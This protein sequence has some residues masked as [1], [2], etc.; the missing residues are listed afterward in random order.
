MPSSRPSCG[1]F[2]AILALT[3]LSAPASSKALPIVEWTACE[4]DLEAAFPALR[5]RLQCARMEVPIDHHTPGTGTLT[6]DVLRIRAASPGARRGNLFINPGGPGVPAFF[7]TASLVGTWERDALASPAKA[8]ISQR[9]DVIAIQ[10][11]GLGGEPLLRCRS[12]AVLHP[13]ADITEDRSDAN[14]L[15]INVHAAAIAQACQA[16]PLARYVNTG[17]TA[18]DMEA[19]RQ[20]LGGEPLNYWGVSWGTELGA[21][22]GALFPHHVDRM[23]LD[24][25]VDWTR[26]LY[27]AWI[28]QGPARQEVFDRF[29]VDRVIKA[30]QTWGLGTSAAEVHARFAG[31]LPASR[32]VM[33]RVFHAPEM[34]LALDFLDR[35]LR[36]EPMLTEEMLGAR[37][38]AHRYSPEDRIDAE[39]RY[40]AGTAVADY[41][42]PPERPSRLEL[43]PGRSVLHSV[44]CQS[45]Q[46]MP[47]P[48]FWDDLGDH[49]AKAYPVGGSD[50]SYEP[51]A[52]WSGPVSPRPDM[53]RLADIPNLVL[54]QAEYDWRTPRH[55]ALNA[56]AQ[57]AGASMVFAQGLEAHGFA[58]N[59]VSACVDEI[60]GRFMADGIKPA[61]MHTCIDDAS[62]VLRRAPAYLQTLQG[63]L[64][65]HTQAER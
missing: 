37:A 13:Y 5:S 49:A 60:S 62:D 23:I 33:R 4:Q 8:R 65:R 21:W 44:S 9:H 38:M 1:L 52:Y 63:H 35:T 48:A 17:Q 20:R 51:C 11:R 32:A 42:T 22:Y 45:S 64:R 18:R 54:L 7:Y 59:G 36:A 29:V 25:N 40:W 27:H 53:R 28:A 24:S 19:V 34:M 47:P 31:F 57:V 12:A 15:A 26:D 61:R 14:L 46:A 3:F 50:N 58:Y 10:P 39:A 16:Q 55:G 41:F 6:L 43:D 30:P 56:H 2:L